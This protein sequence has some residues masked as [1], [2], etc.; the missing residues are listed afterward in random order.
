MSDWPTAT[1]SSSIPSSLATIW[2]SAVA[3]PWPISVLLELSV[4]DPSEWR[5][6]TAVET[7]AAPA[8]EALTATAV[9]RRRPASLGTACG[10]E[11]R[12]D[13]VEVGQEV[14]VERSLAGHHGLAGAKEV[15]PAQLHRVEAEALGC[16]VDVQ[17]AG[18]RALR[19]PRNRGTTMPASCWCRRR[20]RG[21]GGWGCGTDR[22]SGAPTW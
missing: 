4:A 3:L 19:A 8:S 11:G 1:W 5:R 15:A 2:A 16:L 21:R 20:G 14:G 17:L 9:P 10:G 7:G 18:E 6:T 12:G 13:D 22:S